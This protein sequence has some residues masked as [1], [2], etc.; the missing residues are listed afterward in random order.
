MRTAPSRKTQ[1]GA[2]I[3]EFALIL[4][5]LILM[6][7]ITTEFG[8]AMWQYNTLAKSVRD[9]ARYLSL[10]TPGTH[11]TEAQNLL[12]YGNVAGTGAPLVP[13]LSI[14][15]VP[16]PT[17]ENPWWQTA[18]SNPVINTVT[19]RISGYSFNSM[20]GTVFA[21]PFGAVPYSDIKATMRSFL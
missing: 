1:G 10:K 3:V 5:F 13:G 20:F 21:I 18:G 16:A 9:T 11:I 4:P 14:S 15:N 12:V 8:R 19:V 17:G 2:A 7:F 6:S